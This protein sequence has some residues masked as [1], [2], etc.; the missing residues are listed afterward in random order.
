[1]YSTSEHQ[2]PVI[3]PRSGR[4]TSRAAVTDRDRRATPRLAVEVECEER[5]GP[6]TYIRITSDL[7]TFGLS[8]RQGFV[9][10]LGTRLKL[11]LHLPDDRAHPLEVEAEVVGHYDRRWGMRLAFKN[12]SAE[13]GRRIHRYLARART[14]SASDAV[15]VG[16]FNGAA[17]AYAAP[18]D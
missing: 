1:M 12:L 6:S 17:I 14:P 18:H 2:L 10:A 5:V 15:P 4:P 13:A 3:A 11:V 9:H 16:P 7:S 8:T